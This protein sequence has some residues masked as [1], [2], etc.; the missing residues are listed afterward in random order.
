[1][2]KRKNEPAGPDVAGFTRFYK[3]GLFI[4]LSKNLTFGANEDTSVT[5]GK[6][7]RD[8]EGFGNLSLGRVYNQDDEYD[9]AADGV[10][11]SI[12]WC[13]KRALKHSEIISAFNHK[14]SFFGA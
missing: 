7:C 3:N 2:V 9:Y 8:S 5:E 10:A 6:I 4:P 13:W 14:K 1:M 12:V 11:F